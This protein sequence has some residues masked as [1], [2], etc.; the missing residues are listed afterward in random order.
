[1][2]DSGS[3][4]ERDWVRMASV[5]RRIEFKEQSGSPA[6]DVVAIK[7]REIG[8]RDGELPGKRHGVCRE[9]GGIQ[10]DAGQR[11]DAERAEG[12]TKGHVGREDNQ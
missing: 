5:V 4:G 1:M 10:S 11:R 7:E 2:S 3:V 8:P 12:D 6:E 9:G